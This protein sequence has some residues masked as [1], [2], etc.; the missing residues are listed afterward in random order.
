M[1][2][3][4]LLILL[5]TQIRREAYEFHDVYLAVHG[6][7]RASRKNV[8]AHSVVTEVKSTNQFTTQWYDWIG[9]CRSSD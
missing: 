2:Y 7:T 1:G 8:N 3:T 4:T 6:L 5:Y 9:D